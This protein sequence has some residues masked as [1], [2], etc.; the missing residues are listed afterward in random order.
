MSTHKIIRY[1]A[2]SDERGDHEAEHEITFRFTRGRPAVMYLRNGDPG[3]PADPHEV[4]YVSVWPPADAGHQR[5][6][7]EACQEWLQDEGYEQAVEIALE[8]ISQY[9]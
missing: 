5:A 4:E 3:Y 6:L 8:D 2:W 9:H 7:D 1:E